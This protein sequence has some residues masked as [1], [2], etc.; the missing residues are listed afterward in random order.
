[1]NKAWSADQAD[2][3]ATVKIKPKRGSS[4]DASV[5]HEVDSP[6]TLSAPSDGTTS[7]TVR[8]EDSLAKQRRAEYVRANTLPV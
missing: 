4:L 2:V 5:G 1:M 8:V 3:A 6:T 7:S